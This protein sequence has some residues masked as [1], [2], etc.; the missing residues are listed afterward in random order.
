MSLD[1]AKAL[2]SVFAIAPF[3][4][5]N[6]FYSFLCLLCILCLLWTLLQCLF[7]PFD[8]LV[9]A[10]REVIFGIIAQKPPRL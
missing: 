8:C 6:K 1:Y 7:I 4:E 9:K 2:E 3:A 10:A 5:M